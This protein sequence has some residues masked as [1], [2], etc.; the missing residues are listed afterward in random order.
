[1][2]SVKLFLHFQYIRKLP[3]N[4]RTNKNPTG[5]QWYNQTQPCGKHYSHASVS[6]VVGSIV[7][8]ATAWTH[9]RLC[10]VTVSMQRAWQWLTDKSWHYFLMQ[11]R[12]LYSFLRHLPCTQTYLCNYQASGGQCWLC[13][14]FPLLLP[15]LPTTCRSPDNQHTGPLWGQLGW[16]EQHWTVQ[17]RRPAGTSPC[18]YLGHF[19]E[20]KGHCVKHSLMLIYNKQ[21]YRHS[22]SVLITLKTF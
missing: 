8:Y 9:A 15:L 20:D 13:R 10:R 1:M 2:C 3:R 19:C 6:L 11:C 21:R 16:E 12:L 18:S 4:I 5:K 22:I 17:T 14:I 7:Y